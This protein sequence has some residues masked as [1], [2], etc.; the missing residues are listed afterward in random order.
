MRQIEPL[1]RPL[2]GVAAS[3][4]QFRN[5]PFHAVHEK[6]LTAVVDGAGA[7]P[8]MIPAL[9]DASDVAALIAHLD[10][11]VLTGCPSNV[12]PH[13]YGGPPSR[14]DV[15]HDAKRDR[16]TLPLIVAAVEHGVPL[17]C[18]CRGIQELNVAFG[19]TLHQHLHEVPGH[20]DHRRDREAPVEQQ[21]GPRHDIA[22]TPGGLLADLAGGHRTT[23]NSLHG[24]GIDT[25]APRLAV[26]AVADDG[27]VEAV[28]V[29]D[30]PGFAI[31]V[32]WHPEWNVTDN[33]LHGALF[34]AFGDACRQQAIRR[35]EGARAVVLA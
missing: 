26:E 6:Y 20:H 35:A 11:I 23:V 27:T 28:S 17:F 8:V 13:H 4:R 2:V 30:A 5:A 34:R 14:P 16:T 33:R 24:Q 22:I 7:Q 31:G 10:G 21:F 1:P 29:I 18:I 3:V 19:G 9:A 15:P 25:V 12:E 32:Q